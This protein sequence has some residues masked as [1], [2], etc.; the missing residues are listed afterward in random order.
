MGAESGTKI[1]PVSGEDRERAGNKST[2]SKSSTAATAQAGNRTG[3]T[4]TAGGRTDT[5][6]GKTGEK[7][8]ISGLAEP[9]LLTDEQKREERNRR[10]R[11]R[12]AEQK[13]TTVKPRKVRKSKTTNSIDTTEIDKMLC[14]LSTIVASRPN[15]AHWQLTEQEV[16][17]IT[18]PLGNI[19]QK[20]GLFDK[21]TENSNEIALAVAC[22]S[23]F[24]P[25][26]MV[27]VAVAK[28]NAKSKEN[29]RADKPKTQ[30][31]G[32]KNGKIKTETKTEKTSGSRSGR[33]ATDGTDNG[34]H[35]PSYYLSGY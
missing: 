14:N 33:N 35:V 21:V 24:A 9:N 25:R 32:D 27:S 7:E 26:I 12:Y 30:T 5:P 2:D 8:G 20:Y 17:T 11:E 18:Q 15:M 10:R 34:V 19:L 6:G 4:D 13:G 23:V 29:V 16:H 31:G 3:R 22:V 28:Q 1:E